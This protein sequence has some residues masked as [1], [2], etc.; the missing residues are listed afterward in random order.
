MHKDIR[1]LLGMGGVP[2]HDHPRAYAWERRLHWVMIA[3]ALLSIP[4]FYLQDVATASP[5]KA[6]GWELDL[7]IAL[8]FTGELCWMLRI[9]RQRVAYLQNNWLNLLIIM[10][11]G[12]SVI[13]WQT[14][15]L[16][17]VR[18][19]RVVYVGLIIARVIS[20]LRN[21]FTPDAIVSLVILWLIV[22]G[23]VG[24]GF[25]WLEPSVHSFG[26]GLWLAFVTATTTGYGDFV[27]TV[28]ASR[29]LAVMM[30]VLGISILSM[31]TASIAAFFVG[32]DEKRIRHEMHK[33][34]KELR[35]EV[36]QLRS[37]L[38]QGRYIQSGEGADDYSGN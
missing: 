33:D 2:P 26:D 34:I 4:A 21:L 6:L 35:D 9:V 12:L 13:G 20:S 7:I 31:V 36:A 25:Y 22:I 8:I 3:A 11:A 18:L 28:T 27:P 5:L 29:L 17:L 1:R 10:G 38:K 24:A 16:P 37:E 32:E 14:E 15:W 30:V 19:L 23:I